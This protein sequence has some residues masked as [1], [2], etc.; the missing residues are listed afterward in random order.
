MVANKE[1]SMSENF[2][3]IFD[4]LSTAAQIDVI[5]DIILSSEELRKIADKYFPSNYEKGTPV[6]YSQYPG[7][8]KDSIGVVQRRRD[9]DEYV[10][11]Y[12]CKFEAL[13]EYGEDCFEKISE[14]KIYKHYE[15]N[16]YDEESDEQ[17]WSLRH[18]RVNDLSEIDKDVYVY[19]MKKFFKDGREKKVREI[20]YSFKED[21]YYLDML[22]MKKVPV[23]ISIG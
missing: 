15:R 16:G 7:K 5:R 4:G 23:V 12:I 10:V 1:I 20:L 13:I 17:D 8:E 11:F 21:D 9:K 19:E 6:L 2:K 14:I 18:V 22:R 3:K